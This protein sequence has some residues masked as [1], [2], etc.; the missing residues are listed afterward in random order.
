MFGLSSLIM[1]LGSTGIFSS[2]ESLDYQAISKDHLGDIQA[3]FNNQI[4][5]VQVFTGDEYE[6]IA[7]KIIDKAKFDQMLFQNGIKL[8]YYCIIALYKSVL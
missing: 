5:I 2:V 8:K 7:K 6:S 4:I 1:E 3:T